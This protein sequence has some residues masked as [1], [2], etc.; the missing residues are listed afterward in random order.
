[1]NKAAIFVSV[2][3]LVL[4]TGCNSDSHEGR[5]EKLLVYFAEGENWASTFTL[6]DAG[7]S[8][9]DSLYI[10]HIGDRE[11]TMDPIEYTLEGKGIKLASQY[12]QKLQ[13]VR[14][15]QVSGESSKE[16]IDGFEDKDQEYKLT[17]KQNESSEELILKLVNESNRN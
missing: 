14:S 12:P 17:I 9:F 10:Q 2:L 3:L 4:L 13:G 11:S 15:F 8:I 16:L 5:K 1:M 7:E 6:M